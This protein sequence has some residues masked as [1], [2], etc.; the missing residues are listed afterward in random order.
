MNKIFKII[1]NNSKNKLKMQLFNQKLK[2]MIINYLKVIQK[3][4]K[5]LKKFQRSR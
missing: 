3:K 5:I 2:K 4:Q 1:K